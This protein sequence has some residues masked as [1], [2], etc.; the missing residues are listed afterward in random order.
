MNSRHVLPLSKRTPGRRSIMN[1]IVWLV[2]AVVIV[3]A[4]LSFLGLR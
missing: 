4:I 3:V 2:G 1:N